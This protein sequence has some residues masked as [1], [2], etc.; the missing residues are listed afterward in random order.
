VKQPKI[1]RRVLKAIRRRRS[2][3][4]EDERR[5]RERIAAKT[6]EDAIDGRLTTF[7]G[8]PVRYR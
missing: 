8:L 6:V 3:R 7:Y 4:S 1:D 2:D 5:E